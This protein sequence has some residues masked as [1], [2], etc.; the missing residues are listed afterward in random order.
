MKK[1]LVPTDFTE[2][3]ENAFVYA[4]EMAKFY[5]AELVLLHTFELPIVDSQ[6]APINFTEVYEALETT[7][8]NQF[9]DELQKLRDIANQHDAQNIFINH[10]LMDGELMYCIKEVIKQE[11]IDFVVM[12]TKGAS[13]WLESFIGTTTCSVISDVS[14]PV[15]S[16]A[17]DTKFQKIETIGFTTRYRQDEIHSLNDVLTIAKKLDAQVKCLYVKTPD[18]EFIGK[19][20]EYWESIFE[21]ENNLEFF[22]IPSDDVEQTIEDFMVSQNIDLLAMVCHKKSFL[23]RLFTTS[24]TQRMSQHSKTPILALHE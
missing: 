21:D 18:Y 10:I 1:I 19:E 13:G 8:T 4:I 9:K 14:A 23:T 24:T 3:S 17:R 7:N 5:K 20:I 12:G 16:V 15:L 22:I 2:T 6:I 11:N